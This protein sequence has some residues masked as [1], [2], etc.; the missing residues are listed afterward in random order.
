MVGIAHWGAP[1]ERG[2]NQAMGRS[3]RFFGKNGMLPQ[4]VRLACKRNGEP[5]K[6]SNRSYV[7]DSDEAVTTPETTT[8]VVKRAGSIDPSTIRVYPRST[9]SSPIGKEVTLQ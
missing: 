2:L 6:G 9:V 1:D 4:P 5:Y 7:L 8:R 3:V